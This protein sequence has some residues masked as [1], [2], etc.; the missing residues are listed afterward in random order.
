MAKG[1]PRTFALRA[2]AHN[3]RVGSFGTISSCHYRTGLSATKQRSHRPLL[4]SRP[5]GQVTRAKP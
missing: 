4:S 1:R 2:S 3:P 5:S